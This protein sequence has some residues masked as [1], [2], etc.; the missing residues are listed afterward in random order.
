MRCNSIEPIT[1]SMKDA[2]DAGATN[3]IFRRCTLRHGAP[4]LA[5]PCIDLALSIPCRYS[6]GLGHHYSLTVEWSEA[7]SL[8]G[9]CLD[10][11]VFRMWYESS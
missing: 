7:S 11:R 1:E 5:E 4:M 6:E 3:Q 9:A 8:L 10:I 2:K